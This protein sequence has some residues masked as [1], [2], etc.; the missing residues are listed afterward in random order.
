M[1]LAESPLPVFADNIRQ[2][3]CHGE[4]SLDADAI[5]R[6]NYTSFLSAEEL[7]DARL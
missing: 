7:A 3:P 1:H 6:L 5:Y 4:F 2:V